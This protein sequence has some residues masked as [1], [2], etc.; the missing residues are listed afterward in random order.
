VTDW[1]VVFLGVIAVATLVMAAL[2]VAFFV[3]AG[4]AARRVERA[5]ETLHQEV[6]PLI[7]HLDAISRDAKRASSLAAV[8]LERVDRMSAD[9]AERLDRTLN[10]I[11]TA[12]SGG[13]R[14]GVA[15]LAAFRAALAAVRDFRSS[16][17]RAAADDDDALFI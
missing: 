11:Q 4:K 3:G 13:A 12:A 7:E 10:T 6:R 15:M 1:G 17:A 9:L 8:Q 5:A 16:R 14:E 2:Q